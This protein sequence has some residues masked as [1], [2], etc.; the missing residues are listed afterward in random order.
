MLDGVDKVHDTVTTMPPADF[1]VAFRD[2]YD[3]CL[4]AGLAAIRDGSQA[5]AEKAI[6]VSL[7]NLLGLATRWDEP[8]NRNQRGLV[9]RANIMIYRDINGMDKST[10]DRILRSRRFVVGRNAEC[11]F[12]LV[13][14]Y[15]ELDKE[16]T[17]IGKDGTQIDDSLS[18][19][20]L[21]VTFP[22]ADDVKKKLV[23][24]LPG[25]PC[26]FVNGAEDWVWDTK[27]MRKKC[28]ETGA[29]DKSS[30]DD[31]EDYYMKDSKGRSIIAMPISDENGERVAVVNLYRNRP[32][33]LRNERRATEFCALVLPFTVL[34]GR[35][36]SA[37]DAKMGCQDG[38]EA[39]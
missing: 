9:Y 24:N 17:T 36:L 6:R 7:S 22:N 21:A 38:D 15:L 18:D 1:L 5:D 31:I 10:R 2:A 23:L 16:L 20:A 8:V 14:G 26:A 4:E 19:L 3:A 33:I 30:L 29:F 32:E 13:H 25:A 35:L 27:E 28:D 11:T 34:L 12:S 39:P 37:R